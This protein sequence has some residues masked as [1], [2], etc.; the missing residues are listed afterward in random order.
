MSWD[1]K[2]NTKM[3]GSLLSSIPFGGSYISSKE[4]L[5][6]LRKNRPGWELTTSSLGTD[7]LNGIFA[8]PRGNYLELPF[9]VTQ[10]CARNGWLSDKFV[11]TEKRLLS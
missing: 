11:D 10:K 9:E 4:L 6:K 8:L 5:S 7:F 1:G 2:S 3:K